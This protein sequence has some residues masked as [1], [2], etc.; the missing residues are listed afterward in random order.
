MGASKFSHSL[1]LLGEATLGSS[2]SLRDFARL[3]ATMSVPACEVG[4]S[5]EPCYALG[6]SGTMGVYRVLSGDG[7]RLGPVHAGYENAEV[8]RYLR[9]ALARRGVSLRAHAIHCPQVHAHSRIGACSCL[10]FL[11]LGS[12]L[13]LRSAGRKKSVR[14]SAPSS[15]LTVV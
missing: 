13:S 7:N 8:L 3:G 11:H 5:G 6:V 4:A 1:S 15:C 14:C 2:F 12:S 9:K 10:D